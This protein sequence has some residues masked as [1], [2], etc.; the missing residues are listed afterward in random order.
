M[1]LMKSLGINI[2]K[3]TKQQ[4]KEIRLSRV[5]ETR[6]GLV[7]KSSDSEQIKCKRNTPTKHKGV[8]TKRKR[9]LTKRHGVTTDSV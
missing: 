2:S 5:K 8:K 9:K 4:T 1:R 3:F 7:R 6:L